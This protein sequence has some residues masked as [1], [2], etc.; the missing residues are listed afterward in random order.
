M[1]TAVTCAFIGDRMPFTSTGTS[2]SL[3]PSAFADSSATAQM[4]MGMDMRNAAR[5]S[6]P[7]AVSNQSEP[8]TTFHFGWRGRTLSSRSWITLPSG[9][10]R[11]TE[12][13][14]A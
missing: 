2:L 4:S 3:S 14:V 9:R 8:T 5:T 12:S 10:R 6:W 13:P 7:V 11:L 1:A